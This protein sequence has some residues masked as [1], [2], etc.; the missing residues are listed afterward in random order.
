MKGA[1]IPSHVSEA[2]WW[3]LYKYHCSHCNQTK[4]TL[5]TF[6]RASTHVHIAVHLVHT[7]PTIYDVLFAQ[8]QSTSFPQFSLGVFKAAVLFIIM[9]LTQSTYASVRFTTLPQE[10]CFAYS[11]VM[12]R[13]QW[14]CHE[15]A[16]A[17]NTD[18][19]PFEMGTVFVQQY[20]ELVSLQ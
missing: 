10:L 15:I 11:N 19:V 9:I 14:L 18:V 1:D 20:A 7:K 8:C 2:G 13:C 3:C 6:Y 12:L 5:K 4:L 16:N 17:V